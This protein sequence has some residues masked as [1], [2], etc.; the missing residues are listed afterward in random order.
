M[1]LGLQEKG[2]GSKIFLAIKH[3]CICQESK[4]E[5]EGF[6]PVEV[7]NPETEEK[8][9][10]FIKRYRGVAAMITK[11]EWRDTGER[12]DR[13]YTSWRI[14]L[15]MGGAAAVLEIPFHSRH[16]SRF[17]KLAENI[18]YAKPVE[19]RAWYDAKD[20]STAFY[21]GQWENEDD[22]KSLSVPQK[23]TREHP[24]PCPE[25]VQRLGGKWNF[26]DQMDFLHSRMMTIVI[27]QVEATVGMSGE[28]GHRSLPPDGYSDALPSTQPPAFDRDAILTDISNTCKLLND[29][30][31]TTRWTKPSL[32]QFINDKYEVE[33]GLDSLTPPFLIELRDL[34]NKRL[35]DL[36][37]PF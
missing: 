6:E 8:S 17:M 2:G 18:D 3:D 10:K 5:R 24:G 20:K 4:I 29:A 14:H 36:D 7:T 16:S 33:D 12:Y 37:V 23:Y 21:V 13:Q 31:D 35:L 27:P 28:N 1:R 32:R 22:E 34:L 11:I 9:I 19:F 25:P 26:D 30:A 15:D